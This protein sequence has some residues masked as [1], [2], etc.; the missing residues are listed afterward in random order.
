MKFPNFSLLLWYFLN[1]IAG[2]SQG[3]PAW[4]NPLNIA[5]SM[6][7][8]IFNT[9]V[10]FQDSSGVPSVIRWKGDTLIAAF[11]W[12]RSPNPSPTWDKVATKFS[13]DNGITWTQP[14]PIVVHG[15][16]F[17]YQRPFDPA[18]TVF[19]GDSLRL[20]FSSSNGSP[21]KI[22]LDST[23]NTYSAISIDGINY[24]FELGAR[25]DE[26]SNKVIDPSVIYFKGSW[27][28][29]APIGSPQQGAFHYVS[30]DGI[31]FSA[32]PNIPSDSFHN[33]TGNYM[34][35]NTNEIRFYGSGFTIW[36]NSSPNGG[37]WT[38]FVNTNIQGGDPCVLK[39]SDNDYIM[40]YVGR[41]YPT[42]TE[43]I[44]ENSICVS[45]IFPNP[46]S[47]FIEID[48]NDQC[49]GSIFH[50]RDLNGNVITTGKINSAKT[51]TDI[52]SLSAGTYLIYIGNL[53]KFY[54][55]LK[56]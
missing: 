3:N 14:K 32:V 12:F 53:N 29:V 35:E 56:M 42:N 37:M 23:V 6:D 11:Q 13:Y 54:R 28:F 45:P 9:P 47:Q 8:K 15:L 34:I 22:G 49:I 4:N 43:F 19:S 7:G 20:Y 46:A 36:Y 38:G 18:L 44:S 21:P 1:S 41:P 10:V 48:T 55:F 5:R 27:H 25:V 52:S 17:N 50:I 40:I 2:F 26:P 39:I 31:K 24:F 30:P 16:P 51:L 33:W